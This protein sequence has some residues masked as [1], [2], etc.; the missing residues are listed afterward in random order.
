MKKG[1]AW[2]LC[3][4]MALS[5]FGGA[6]AVNED[7]EGELVIYSSMYPAILDMMNEA[8]KEEFP[9]LTPGNDGHFFFYEG[10]GKMI[11]RIRGEMT[12]THDHALGCDMF[13][14]AEPSFSLE[15][16]EYG[17]LHP[18]TFEGAADKLRFPY[19]EEGY[20][21]PVRVCNMVLAYNPEKVEEFAAKGI[22]IPKTF[23]DFAYDPALKGYISMG[24]P[25]TSGTSYAAVVSL[26]GKYGEEYLEKLGENNVMRESGSTAIEKLQS[27][28]CAVIMIL[29]ESILKYMEDE[30]NRGHEVTN[31]QVIYP[32]DG[33][34][35]I[36][37]TVMIVKDE[38]SKNVNSEAAEAVAQW[39]LSEAGQRMIVKGYMHSVLK[40]FD[41]IPYK[42]V[43]TDS[44]I[45]KDLGVDWARAYR[46]RNAINAMWTEKVT[47]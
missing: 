42:S 44:L 10:T 35:L 28:E 27:G 38:Y 45:K 17:Y 19:D 24:D 47:R 6:L 33:V 37:S 22:T 41:E 46:E 15:M 11:E 12:E 40:D 9:N 13:M 29:E 1:L 26:L 32:E 3:L 4:M 7:V 2:L 36:P 18:F 31:L 8:L 23:H 39:F 30:A 43:S 5:A 25:A 34:V 20:W 16:K 21:Y 14:V